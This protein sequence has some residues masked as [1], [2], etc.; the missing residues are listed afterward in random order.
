[1]V[2]AAGVAS[3]AL[4]PPRGLAVSRV[5]PPR[6][7]LRPSPG[8]AV[9]GVQLEAVVSGD[10]LVSSLIHR[11]HDPSI[12]DPDCEACAAELQ[13]RFPDVDEPDDGDPG[14]ICRECGCTDDAPC[15]EEFGPCSWIEPDLCSA[16][17]LEDFRDED[18]T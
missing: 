10:R 13:E 11:P 5:G 15:R 4:L 8:A 7:H 17:A 18:T 9:W 16:C 2:A 14:D 12:D 6:K 3:G 1:M